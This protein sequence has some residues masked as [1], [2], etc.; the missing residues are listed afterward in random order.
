[1]PINVNPALLGIEEHKMQAGMIYR[2]QWNSVTSP[3]NSTGAFGELRIEPSFLPGHT[4]GV[5]LQFLNDVSSG[6]ALRQNQLSGALNYIKLIGNKQQHLIAG[7]LKAVFYQRSIDASNLAFE[8]DFNYSSG[9]FTTVGGNEN[10]QTRLSKSAPDFGLGLT[11]TFFNSKGKPT[12]A[13]LSFD[14]LFEPN[15]SLENNTQP[16]DRK[17]GFFLTS[18]FDMGKKASMK[19]SVLYNRQQEASFF[20]AGTEVIYPVGRALLENTDLRIG[21][22]YRVDDAVY[23]TF[24]INHDNWSI[25]FAYDFT[26]SNL[27]EAA[28][29]VNA[30][31]ICINIRN[32]LF[33][34]EKLR[35][36]LPGNRF[37]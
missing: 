27:G 31:E 13:G 4:F 3:F 29:N 35:Y 30:F 19:P 20:I 6:G 22:Y 16:L 5:G 26:T 9:S 23:F 25:L 24:G 7:A 36:I 10:M 17:F 11:Y 8:S 15:I 1:M 14:H 32:R 18:L 21:M 37:F 2:N 12:T 28:R 33:Q 34:P